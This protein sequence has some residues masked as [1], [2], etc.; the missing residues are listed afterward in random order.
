MMIG[1]KPCFI[2][3]VG[4][5]LRSGTLTRT[6]EIVVAARLAAAVSDEM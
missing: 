1:L 5:I 6:A 2:T 3:T 4:G